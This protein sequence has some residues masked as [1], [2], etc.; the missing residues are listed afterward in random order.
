MLKLLFV[1]CTTGA[2]AQQQLPVLNV[3]DHEIAGL[4]NRMRSEDANQAKPSQYR[5]DFQ[6]HTAG[7]DFDDR[8]KRPLIEYIDSSVLRRPTYEHLLA[9]FDNFERTTGVSE[10]DT[11][12]EIEEIKRFIDLVVETRPWKVLIEFLKSKNHPFVSNPSTLK[13]MLRQL[14]FDHYS[15]ARGLADTSAFEHIFIGETKNGEIS[16]LHNWLRLYELERNV[17]S[18]FD[19]R[20][21]LVK[22]GQIMGAIKFQWDGQVKRAGSMF[23][24][25]SPEFELGLYTVCFFGASIS[26]HL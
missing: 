26:Q 8:A 11:P 22:R 7:A 6:G 1:L 23:F 25:T 15:R 4:V 18:R 12:E 3:M 17:S 2:L 20:G 9:L 10:Q 14:W 21:F 19:Y 16:G 13:R 5:L 24:G